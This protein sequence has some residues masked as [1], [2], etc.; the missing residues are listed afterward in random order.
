MHT[1]ASSISCLR[2]FLPVK[3]SHRAK[4]RKIKRSEEIIEK[5]NK[6]VREKEIVKVIILKHEREM[7]KNSGMNF[8]ARPD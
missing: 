2:S 7:K 6:E 5:K 1:P 8:T 3:T 4:K